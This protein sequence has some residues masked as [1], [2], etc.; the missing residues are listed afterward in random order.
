MKYTFFSNLAFQ[1]VDLFLFAKDSLTLNSEMIFVREI[2][3]SK[4][5][6]YISKLG[7]CSAKL[8]T[9]YLPINFAQRHFQSCHYSSKGKIT[10]IE[11]RRMI[12]FTKLYFFHL[13]K[14]IN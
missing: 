7:N 4:G 6:R 5:V 8:A 14:L 11:K 12:Y 2:Y 3:G 10:E 13:N 9:H 1:T